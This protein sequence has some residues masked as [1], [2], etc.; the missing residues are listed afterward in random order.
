MPISVRR[1]ETGGK[2][3]ASLPVTFQPFFHR[4]VAHGAHSDAADADEVGLLGFSI[5]HV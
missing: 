4:A 1:V 5:K 2:K 3:P